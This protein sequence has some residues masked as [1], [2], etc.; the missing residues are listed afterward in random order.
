MSDT[1]CQLRAVLARMT[2]HD[3]EQWNML[4]NNKH[5]FLMGSE[6]DDSDDKC[7]DI[8]FDLDEVQD[9]NPGFIN[10]L[11]SLARM[12]VER[13]LLTLGASD[14]ELS[15]WLHPLVVLHHWNDIDA[16]TGELDTR[17]PGWR[18][19]PLQRCCGKSETKCCAACGLNL[20]FRGCWLLDPDVL[21]KF[22]VADWAGCAD[23]T[24]DER[25]VS[26]DRV[27][28]GLKPMAL[29][30]MRTVP[31]F[32][33]AKTK[34]L[35]GLVESAAS[36]SLNPSFR[37]Y[38]R[39]EDLDKPLN[40]WVNFDNLDRIVN[41]LLAAHNKRPQHIAALGANPLWK[42]MHG[43][44]KRNKHLGREANFLEMGCVFGYPIW[45]SIC[46]FV[47]RSE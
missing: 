40:T 20:A 7:S 2:P 32:R 6:S 34:M 33:R 18:E 11:L 46:L 28:N 29:E 38:A 26:L 43:L 17:I 41:V 12:M 37:F 25:L 42:Y 10:A 30:N 1:V 19:F 3:R 4:A 39:Q 47:D 27:R 23:G 8:L 45:T 36:S 15:A 13:P 9:V 24:V 16:A 5:N 35:R 14:D 31:G 44:E 21:G 22:L